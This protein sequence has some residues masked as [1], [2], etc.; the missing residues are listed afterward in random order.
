MYWAAHLVYLLSPFVR[1]PDPVDYRFVLSFLGDRVFPVQTIFYYANPAWWFFGLL[2]ELCLAFPLLFRLLQRTGPVRFLTLTAV[3]TVLSR[4]LLVEVIHAN[5]NYLQ[6]AFFGARLFEF[7]AGM[8]LAVLYQRSPARVETRLFSWPL[9]VAG[10]S[11]YWLGVFCYRPG[12]PLTLSDALT[13]VGLS[14]VVVQ[15]SRWFNC[16]PPL[17]SILTYVGAY[18]YGIYLLHQP[19]VMYTGERLNGFSMPVAVTAVSGVL[20]LIVAG[21]SWIERA[22]ERLTGRG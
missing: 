1:R 21:A 5:G 22:L 17:R 14:I 4:Y 2:L 3:A 20:V 8:V 15:V 7:A 9:L 11:M 19:Y 10:A 18:S 6:G 16:L 12:F 13:G